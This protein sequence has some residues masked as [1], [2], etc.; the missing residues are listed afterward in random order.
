MNSVKK[1][2]GHV[3][4]GFGFKFDYFY[5]RDL[6]SSLP[7]FS[8]IEE[9]KNQISMIFTLAACFFE[10]LLVFLSIT[11]TKFSFSH[12][13]AVLPINICWWC[14]WSSRSD[15]VEDWVTQEAG[16]HV[17]SHWFFYWLSIWNFWKGTS[18][19]LHEETKDHSD[20][21]CF[22]LLRFFINSLLSEIKWRTSKEC[23]YE[24]YRC[25]KFFSYNSCHENCVKNF[26][27]WMYFFIGRFD[28]C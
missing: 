12:S 17:M 16:T 1:V 20:L 28:I 13:T 5:H 26:P 3:S 2:R 18:Y 15:V 25:R 8:L 7:F 27:C 10:E 24:S 9:R 19:S 14:V 11:D 6:T 22:V 21:Y 4:V 23:E